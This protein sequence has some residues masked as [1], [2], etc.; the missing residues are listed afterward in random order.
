MTKSTRKRAH[1]DEGRQKCPLQQNLQQQQSQDD[2]FIPLPIQTFLWRQTSPFVRPSIGKSKDLSLIEQRDA[3]KLFERIIITNNVWGQSPSLTDAI[4]SIDRWSLIKVSFPFVLQCTASLLNNKLIKDGNLNRL[5]GNEAKMMYTLQWILMNA[6]EECAD[7][8]NEAK[9]A[10]ATV[11]AAS[12]LK[13]SSAGNLIAGVS[14]TL[15]AG[16]AVGQPALTSQGSG[17]SSA[18]TSANLDQFQQQSSIRSEQ[19][20]QPSQIQPLGG[21]GSSHSVMAALNQSIMIP[22][23]SAA[24]GAVAVAIPATSV[25]TQ[26]QTQT[27]LPSS[28]SVS[29]LGSSTP[30]KPLTPTSPT[31]SSNNYLLPISSIQMFVHHFAPIMDFLKHSDFLTSN[32]RLEIGATLWEPLFN[33]R[34]PNVQCLAAQIKQ[35]WG[36]N[37]DSDRTAF[38]STETRNRVESLDNQTSQRDD[39]RRR[40][41]TMVYDQSQ[42][43][44]VFLGGTSISTSRQQKQQE[45]SLAGTT[46]KT[47]QAPMYSMG[48]SESKSERDPMIERATYLDIAIL[49]CLFTSNWQESGVYWALTF[50]DKRFDES[51][52]KTLS[53]DRTRTQALSKS[54]PNVYAAGVQI[55][56]MM[57]GSSKLTRQQDRKQNYRNEKTKERGKSSNQHCSSP[58]NSRLRV[59]D[60]EGDYGDDKDSKNSIRRLSFTSGMQTLAN[61][62]RRTS[63][64]VKKGTENN[65][66]QDDDTCMSINQNESKGSKVRR[67]SSADDL[68]ASQVF[69]LTKLHKEASDVESRVKVRHPIDS[70]PIITITTNNAPNLSF[71]GQDQTKS[72]IDNNKVVDLN[73]EEDSI[74]KED[75]QFLIKSLYLK[76]LL[77]LDHLTRSQS[78]P[79]NIHFAPFDST[80]KSR[81]DQSSEST[82]AAQYV[83]DEGRIDPMVMLKVAHSIC[84]RENS[85]SLRVCDRVLSI[86]QKLLNIGILRENF[87]I[88]TLMDK[89]RDLEDLLPTRQNDF[90]NMPRDLAA[91]LN[92][93]RRSQQVDELVRRIKL[94]HKI[95]VDIVFHLYHHMGCPNNCGLESTIDHHSHGHQSKLPSISGRASLNLNGSGQSL[96]RA[97]RVRLR[98][99]LN[100][101]FGHDQSNFI[102]YVRLIVGEGALQQ[103]VDTLHGVLGFCRS[104]Y[105]VHLANNSIKQPTPS[106]SGNNISESSQQS[107]RP[108]DNIH[109]EGSVLQK[110]DTL[111]ESVIIQN[112]FRMLVTQMASMDQKSKLQ[113]N[114][115][116]YCDVRRLISFVRDNYNTTFRG[117]V[118]SAL[119]DSTKFFSQQRGNSSDNG[120]NKQAGDATGPPSDDESQQFNG[121]AN[122]KRSRFSTEACD[123]TDNIK[124]TQGSSSNAN[125]VPFIDSSL[126][127]GSEHRYSQ[128][129]YKM[130]QANY[131][132]H[133]RENNIQSSGILSLS[134]AKRKLEQVFGG[135]QGAKV[136]V[137]QTNFGDHVTG[138]IG[139]NENIVADETSRRASIVGNQSMASFH[140][141]TLKTGA[142]LSTLVTPTTLLGGT[143]SR[144]N[145]LLLKT[146]QT[147]MTNFS[148]L[149]DSSPPGEFLDPA[150]LAALLDLKSPIAIRA[151]IFFECANLVNRCNRGHW[152]PWMKMNISVQYRNS[153]VGLPQSSSMK[154]RKSSSM[155]R[156][157]RNNTMMY[158]AA[159]K[160]FYSWA[161]AVGT[162]LEELLQMESSVV[163]DDTIMEDSGNDDPQSV[164]DQCTAS[165]SQMYD[166]FHSNEIDFLQPTS[167]GSTCPF[168]LKMAACQLLLEVTTFLRETYRYLPPT[169]AHHQVSGSKMGDKMAS[170]YDV[171]RAVT[172][173]RRWSM[174]LSSLGFGQLPATLNAISSSATNQG[175]SS[176]LRS[177]ATSAIPEHPE[178]RISFVLHEM[179]D[180][181]DKNPETPGQSQ[182]QADGSQGNVTSPLASAVNTVDQQQDAI[183]KLTASKNLSQSSASSAVVVAAATCLLRSSGMI[184]SQT[185]RRKSIKLR[186]PTQDKEQRDKKTKFAQDLDEEMENSSVSDAGIR[187]T[188]SMRSRRRVSGISE[189]SDASDRPVNGVQQDVRGEL[190]GE[191]SAGNNSCDDAYGNESSDRF[192][193]DQSRIMSNMPWFKAIAL[194][195]SNI[196]CECTHFPS[197]RSKCYKVH[198]DMCKRLISS[199]QG[200]Y[201]RNSED[202]G[203]LTTLFESKLASILNQQSKNSKKTSGGFT[204]TGSDCS[205]NVLDHESRRKEKK[206]KR[207]HQSGDHLQDDHGHHATPKSKRHHDKGKSHPS[208]FDSITSANGITPLVT[209]TIKALD[210]AKAKR[211]TKNSQKK[212]EPPIFR[213]VR[214]NVKNLLHCPMSSFLK[215][216][217]ILPRESFVD[218]IRFS[219]NLLLEDEQQLS[220][221]AAVCF[222][223]SSIKCPTEATELLMDELASNDASRRIAAINKFHVVWDARY[224]CWP[225]LEDGA[226]VH[227]KMAPPSIEFTLPSPKI[228]QESRPVI[229]P[230]WMPRRTSNVE[231]VTIGQDQTVQRSFVTATKTRRK[232]QIEIVNKALREKHD[233]LRQGRENY[234]ITSVPITLYAAYEPAL[235][236]Q[237]SGDETDGG[238]NA[239]DE[240]AQQENRAL[241]Q[242]KTAQALFPTCLCQAAIVLINLLDDSRV[243]YE[244]S[245]VY[246]VSS[247]VI[248]SCLVEDPSLFLRYFF[249][250][251]TRQNQNTIFQVLRRLIRFMPRLPP[252]AAFTLYNYLVGFIIFYVRSPVPISQKLIADTLSVLCH[253]V[254][255]VY[256]LFLK[257]LKQIFRREQCDHSLLIT[258][259]VPS[260]K[261]IIIHGSDSSGIPSQFPIDETTQ[262]YHILI[263][264]LEFF[265]I[266]KHKHNEYFLIDVR[267]GQMHNLQ[268]YVRDYYSF[269]RSQHPQLQLVCLNPDKAFFLL[270]KQ[271]LINQ[272][273]EFGKVLM[274]RTIVKSAHLAEGR[275]SLLQEDLMK[276]PT[277]PRRVLETNF[278]LFKGSTGHQVFSMDRIHKLC[279]VRIIARMFELTSGFYPHLNEIHPFLIAVCGVF[280]VHC[281]EAA[282]SRLCLA[283]FINAAHQF[284]DI[285]A[286]DGF[287]SI[288]ATIVQVYSNHQN[289]HLLCRSIEFVCKQFY[290]M[291]RKPFLLQLFGSVAA[292]LDTTEVMFQNLANSPMSS[293]D[294]LGPGGCSSSVTDPNRISPNAFFR[295]LQSLERAFKDPMDILELVDLEKP[296]RAVDFC[297]QQDKE[298]IGML[299]I[300]SLCVTVTAYASESPR[301][302][303]MLIILESV[304]P[305]YMRFLQTCTSK[306]AG[307]SMGKQ[308]H[309]D[310]LQK[311]QSISIC[312]RT[313]IV[314]C[315]G[316]TRNFNGPM[317]FLDFRGSSIR[318]G[319]STNKSTASQVKNQNNSSGS[320]M[321]I[322]NDDPSHTGPERPRQTI[323]SSGKQTTI[324]AGSAYKS[325]KNVS[326]EEME[327]NRGEFIVPRDTLLNLTAEFLSLSTVRL[328]DS[329]KKYV[330]L[331]QKHSSYELLDVKSHLR[332]AEIANSLLKLASTDPSVMA[333]RGL[334]RYMNEILPNTEWRQ[335]AI[336]PALIMILKRLDK[337][338]NRIAKKSSVK[339]NTDWEGA[340]QLL[341]G[342]YLTFI[343]HPYI[344]HLPHLKSLISCCQNIILSDSL[345]PSNQTF[346]NLLHSFSSNQMAQPIT[347]VSQ[348]AS[349]NINEKSVFLK[350]SGSPMTPNFSN[351]GQTSGLYNSQARSP[352]SSADRFVSAA[353][354]SSITSQAFN[355]VTVRLIAMQL[356]QAGETQTLESIVGNSLNTPEKVESLML[357]LIYPMCIRVCS[358]SREAP[359]L[360]PCDITFIL[361]IVLTLLAPQSASIKS[362]SSISSPKVAADTSQFI[363]S[364]ITTTIG[365]TQTGATALGIVGSSAHSVAGTHTVA[366]HQE[367]HKIGFLGLKILC[368]CFELHLANEWVRIARVIRDLTQQ[369]GQPSGP[370]WDFLDFLATFR[371]PLLVL[372]LPLIRC[373]LARKIRDDDKIDSGSAKYNLQCQKLIN[374]K[375][376]NSTTTVCR[377]RSFLFVSLTAELRML[378]EQLVA[379]RRRLLE[380]E[381]SV[382]QNSD[383][384]SQAQGAGSS[385]GQNLGSQPHRLSA[386]FSMFANQGSQSKASTSGSGQQLGTSAALKGTCFVAQLAA[387][388]GQLDGSSS[389]NISNG[390]DG[391]PG[392]TQ[393]SSNGQQ[394]QSTIML[395]S[396][397]RREEARMVM[398]NILRRTS[399][400][401]NSSTLNAPEHSSKNTDGSNRKDSHS[402]SPSTSRIDIEAGGSNQTI[403]DPAMLMMSAFPPPRKPTTD[404]P[405]I[406]KQLIQ[407]ID[408]N[409]QKTQ[410]MYQ[411]TSLT[412][413]SDLRASTSASSDVTAP[414][415]ATTSHSRLSP[416]ASM[417]GSNLSGSKSQGSLVSSHRHPHP[418]LS[419]VDSMKKK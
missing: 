175:G 96:E 331:H 93:S 67:S 239:M 343:K 61:Q 285:F 350:V 263:D 46:T 380:G 156:T 322:Y 74:C 419:K 303:Q 352:L 133:E 403:L 301:S 128:G 374:A 95:L 210:A 39:Q 296:L 22:A 413:S 60:N 45:T 84:Q 125:D 261:K 362:S 160:A 3:C 104:D 135:K 78:I 187:R 241:I 317:P 65:S 211:E 372:L 181:N 253:V 83:D 141:Q 76:S 132:K 20:Y 407:T 4:A 281:E 344:V 24:V 373:H 377:S 90:L 29:P 179:N 260:A 313:L 165:A 386:A 26:L 80:A 243:T 207:H 87:H 272:F 100:I 280:V 173:N 255:S 184:D 98:A 168:A 34:L 230:P 408:R 233:M 81:H 395:T 64:R 15:G 279:W 101:L 16:I 108:V 33:H 151:A 102:K 397:K 94:I 305:L 219:W 364:K 273:T 136:K 194:V 25:K 360:R 109:S 328:V 204:R 310:E 228:A 215:G 415:G 388:G 44:D 400:P 116:L 247:K 244:G 275:A 251:L 289:N 348:S 113:E 242:M 111:V 42:F 162:R 195:N 158:R 172:A 71:D 159:G 142:S 9:V 387:P 53:L 222:I 148:F 122:T 298:V 157:A 200:I 149:M 326:N 252:Q 315:E 27:T 369:T 354:N 327:L 28:S 286:I 358:G 355:S 189:K 208:H 402:V 7:S 170:I 115:A 393:D 237:A 325:N 409:N 240:D 338:F 335:E 324:I 359:K 376:Q 262:F 105:L 205:T 265:G 167:N 89:H 371:F 399:Y 412:Q 123:G 49:R 367:S 55:L 85:C 32:Q 414:S 213:Y 72:E 86:V 66:T 308:A 411:T 91:E 127:S 139:F 154:H 256:A 137:N 248:W 269:K 270:Q 217:V 349:M 290:I 274:S 319:P 153:S 396:A 287:T 57:Q 361:N 126:A 385:L 266:E 363:L 302:T 291:H 56:S 382:N 99:T 333:C 79:R 390:S 235:S 334:T 143:K 14:G 119:I 357:N 226:F 401:H 417:D 332:L 282:A 5:G 161:E 1:N 220:R 117:I 63:K 391:G 283:T 416:L 43:G 150:L 206:S 318:R 345:Q 216:A 381:R 23:A 394:S 238:T 38:F 232:Q 284:K 177:P 347:S 392:L 2:D 209:D 52:Y 18:T 299:D 311:I 129:S 292:K 294:P 214:A 342:A 295:L 35:Q 110:S 329:A 196:D 51:E 250:R 152:P 198:R 340:K 236:V 231:E 330:D 320:P 218:M 54:L 378:K 404:S 245:A 62:I 145:Q 75:L 183:R 178:R 134:K 201:K 277:F 30:T 88:A 77:R 185:H 297:Y 304:V 379:K 97:V 323:G 70:H 121:T 309:K 138:S 418:S 267:T 140:E 356:L 144:R 37:I 73:K 107:V 190:S 257:D 147:G 346:S 312:I 124:Y 370:L 321:D 336:R 339:R 166:N 225:R 383:Q 13:P 118:L 48:Q 180:E 405:S 169:I 182:S 341:K 268:S 31:C 221:T 375:I 146:I 188:D 131:Q 8:E 120:S 365:S 254:P 6:S 398:N 276:L 288:M 106:T 163:K 264:S 203:D 223:I 12:L 316:L 155:Q 11:G 314:N 186:K 171:S 174:A 229:D 384:Q 234:H 368:V 351:Q 47:K 293:N 278:N 130:Y 337:T 69:A 112:T 199:V 246:E 300:I 406:L 307:Q 353:S 202:E 50:L 366:Q 212:E 197:C 193:A 191:E 10:L 58:I 114:T 306:K 259:N 410:S 68:N 19:T 176:H 224:Q 41:S 227:F 249:E 258:A 21:T 17:A 389:A 59:I 192:E 82:A 40:S 164:S 36:M 103:V 271:E 92:A